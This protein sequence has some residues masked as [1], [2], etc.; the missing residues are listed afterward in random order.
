MHITL[1]TRVLPTDEWETGTDIDFDGTFA[2]FMESRKPIQ[3]QDV[4]VKDYIQAA[5]DTGTFKVI[6]PANWQE[7]V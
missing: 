4:S 1:A 7:L 2:E 3:F 5:I 6:E